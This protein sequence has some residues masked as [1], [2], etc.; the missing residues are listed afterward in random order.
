[1]SIRHDRNF[2]SSAIVV[3]VAVFGLNAGEAFVG[4]IGPLIEVPAWIAPVNVAFWL[5]RRYFVS[6]RRPGDLA[7]KV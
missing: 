7:M 2:N 3:A 5:R 6:A 1:M 4:M